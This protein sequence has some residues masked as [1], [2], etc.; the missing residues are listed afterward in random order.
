MPNM[1]AIKPIEKKNIFQLS[2]PAHLPNVSTFIQAH[3]NKSRPNWHFNADF[4]IFIQYIST[5]GIDKAHC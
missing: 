4:D 1:C 3:L 5:I 2:Q